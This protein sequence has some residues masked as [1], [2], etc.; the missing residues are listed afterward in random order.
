MRKK[1]YIAD[2]E[3]DIRSLLKS[4]LEDD[5]EVEIFENGDK[6][7][8]RFNESKAD[9]IILDIMM[10]GTDGFTICSKI[11]KRSEIPIILLTAKDMDADFV[12]GFTMG[13]D[14][15]FTKPFSPVKLALRVKS[16]FARQTASEAVDE[17]DIYFCDLKMDIRRKQAF[18]KNQ[19]MHLTNTEYELLS[20]LLKNNDRAVSREEL[21]DTV[22]GYDSEIETRA[23]DDTIKR[24]RKKITEAG[25]RVSIQT[26]WGFGFRVVGEE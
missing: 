24:L 8:E 7:F 23:T 15:Y 17:K 6:L 14:D 18:C 21:L 1:I 9:L 13:C 3:A 20:Y 19:Q 25:S 26:V 12:T 4:F 2:D 11:R 22:W 5:Y 16:I 10:P